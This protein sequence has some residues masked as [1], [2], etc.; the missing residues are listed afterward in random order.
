MKQKILTVGCAILLAIM[1]I[2]LT[3]CGGAGSTNYSED[4]Q[5]IR[6]Q[7]VGLLNGKTFGAILDVALENAKW[8]ED[9]SYSLTSG[10]VKVEGKDKESG[11]DVEII[12]LK[13]AQEAGSNFE[14]MTKGGE[15]IGYSEFLS[16]LQDYEDQ[17]EE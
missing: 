15:E 3:G 8:S 13:E 16:Y 6:N 4:I 1:L 17:I 5:T 12:W 11:E 9:D 10:A 2:T 7:T 14:K